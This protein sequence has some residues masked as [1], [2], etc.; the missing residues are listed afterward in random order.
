MMSTGS[1]GWSRVISSSTWIPSNRLPCNHTSST[2]RCG[3]RCA[4]EFNAA[5]ESDATR[6]SNPSS[7]RIPAISSRISASSSTTRISGETGD[8]FCFIHNPLCYCGSSLWEYQCH[9]RAGAVLC[10]VVLIVIEQ[11]FAAM[12]FKNFADDGEPDP[13]ALLACGDIWF[14]QPVTIFF[15]Q[16]DSIIANGDTDAPTAH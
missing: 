14:G 1:S 12:I 13:R 10:A 8:P 15:R 4:I 16:A 6:V 9:D 5:S 3:R 2:T 7:A 11:K